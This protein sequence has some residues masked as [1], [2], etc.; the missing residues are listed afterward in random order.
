MVGPTSSVTPA[1]MCQKW[2]PSNNA[3]K[4]S[5]MNARYCSQFRPVMAV[6]GNRSAG[7]GAGVAR[8]M[9]G[10]VEPI[11][12]IRTAAAVAIT[13]RKRTVRA[14]MGLV[15]TVDRA[16]YRTRELLEKGKCEEGSSI[17]GKLSGIAGFDAR[18]PDSCATPALKIR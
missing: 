3:I 10:K 11:A 15:I 17:A 16:L 13:L 18:R 2:L 8:A 6:P 9:P 1:G 5:D 4:P 7:G 14:R 12:A